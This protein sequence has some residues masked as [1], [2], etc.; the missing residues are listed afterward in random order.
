MLFSAGEAE[1][2]G[3]VLVPESIWLTQRA[4]TLAA[5]F[6]GW[7]ARA[8]PELDDDPQS[9]AS[10]GLLVQKAVVRQPLGERVAARFLVE[11]VRR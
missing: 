10:N 3:L 8:L 9:E 2:E 5:R 6:E 4:P 11:L 7:A 1:I